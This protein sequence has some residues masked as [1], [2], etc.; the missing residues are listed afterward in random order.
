MLALVVCYGGTGLGESLV[1]HLVNKGFHSDRYLHVEVQ[2]QVHLEIFWAGE[3]FLTVSA[4][5]VTLPAMNLHVS[6]QIAVTGIRLVAVW[7]LV[8]PVSHVYFHM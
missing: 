5:S 4:L 1:A 8:R 3:P 6:F 7:T 2:V